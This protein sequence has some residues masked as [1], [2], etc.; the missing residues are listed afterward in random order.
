MALLLDLPEDD[1]RRGLDRL[2]NEL[3][4]Q[5]YF[6]SRPGQSKILDVAVDLTIQNGYVTEG[7]LGR[8][9]IKRDYEPSCDNDVR[10]YKG[11]LKRSMDDFYSTDGKLAVERLHI[12]EGAYHVEIR[13]NL[14]QK[15]RKFKVG[16]DGTHLFTF[17]GQ[18]PIARFVEDEIR[19][20]LDASCTIDLISLEPGEMGDGV[21]C[22][23]RLMLIRADTD[24][25]CFY[26]VDESPVTSR[27]NFRFV[28]K[29]KRSASVDLCDEVAQS[30][31]AE[32]TKLASGRAA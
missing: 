21:D 29:R 1:P 12:P 18:D 5:P 8:R 27:R 32:I 26:D 22:V 9:A 17:C 4:R 2:R 24:L 7:D 23:L 28:S 25:Y 3:L 6:L 31:Y 11:R 30:L 14:Q 20:N 15:S 10:I 19:A 16:V 13:P